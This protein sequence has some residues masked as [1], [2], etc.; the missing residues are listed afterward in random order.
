[1]NTKGNNLQSHFYQV[2]LAVSPDKMVVRQH[3]SW[4]I[5][6]HRIYQAGEHGQ[7]VSVLRGGEQ[8]NPLVAANMGFISRGKVDGL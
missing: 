7:G 6:T 8:M 3:P 2:L 4:V 1:M 5:P